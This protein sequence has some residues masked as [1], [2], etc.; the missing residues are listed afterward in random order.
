MRRFPRE[1]VLTSAN[2]D[3]P[4]L[5]TGRCQRCV[6]DLVYLYRALKAPAMVQ[7]HQRLAERARAE[8]WTHEEFLAAWLEQEVAAR[9][10][11][12]LAIA[13]AGSGRRYRS[14]EGG[15]ENDRQVGAVNRSHTERV[16]PVVP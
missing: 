9:Q 12:G 16:A 14:S 3:L 10:A 8:D 5:A 13:A 6:A 11:N 4:R 1:P 7:P 15:D 2:R